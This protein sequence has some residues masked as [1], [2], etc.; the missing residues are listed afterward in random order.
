MEEGTV[1]EISR[2]IV[3]GTHASAVDIRGRGITI[4]PLVI[5]GKDRPPGFELVI[6]LVAPPCR[7][8]GMLWIRLCSL[9]NIL[10]IA[11]MRVDVTDSPFDKARS[12]HG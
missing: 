10:Q 12:G 6:E 11:N 9:V 7:P 1:D 3:L 8:T 4:R 2:P 5:L